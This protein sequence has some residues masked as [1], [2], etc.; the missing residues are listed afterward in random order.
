MKIKRNKYKLKLSEIIEDEIKQNSLRERFP[1]SF[2][3][4]F[5]KIENK[6]IKYHK[7]FTSIPFV[8][9]DGEDSKDFDDAVWSSNHN[10]LTT[11]MVAISDV[12]FFIEKND[13]LDIEVTVH[14]VLQTHKLKEWENVST[15]A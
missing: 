3:T 2:K 8:T 15:I 14:Q 7:D 12:S 10:G 1:K 6:K 4:H 9:I 5:N 11:I 13:P